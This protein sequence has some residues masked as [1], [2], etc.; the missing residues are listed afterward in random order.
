MPY[1]DLTRQTTNKGDV[2]FDGQNGTGMK[3]EYALLSDT[4]PLESQADFDGSY[5]EFTSDADHGLSVGDL[6]TLKNAGG[7]F[8]Y[9]ASYPDSFLV[10][11]TVPTTDTFTLETSAGAAVA[12]DD[13]NSSTHVCY[14]HDNKGGLKIMK[15]AS[16]PAFEIDA[17]TGDVKVD[18]TL[19]VTGQTLFIDTAQMNFSDQLLGINFD[20]GTG[21]AEDLASGSEAGFQIGDDD[22]DG[23]STK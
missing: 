15:D 16:T 14:K 9:G 18:G 8:I 22:F 5:A 1:I 4:I 11:K 12:Y 20:S 23:S 21:A 2:Q 13:N 10:V 19:T 3:W 6:V 17:T 7:D